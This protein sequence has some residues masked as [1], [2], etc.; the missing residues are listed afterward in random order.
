MK[1]CVG[2]MLALL[3]LPVYGHQYI[4]NPS[5][6]FNAIQAAIDDAHDGDVVVLAPGLYVSDG[7]QPLLIDSK[8]I[9]LR[10]QDANDAGVVA[11]TVLQCP[12]QDGNSVP[13]LV[14][15]GSPAL[16]TVL[17][18]I[19]VTGGLTQAAIR[20][21]N[22]YCAIRSCVIR[23]NQ[24]GGI[25]CEGSRIGL[26]QCQLLHNQAENGGGLYTE[27]ATV[28]LIDCL[29]QG[30]EAA[31]EGGAVY[32]DDSDLWGDRSQWIGNRA[33]AG[34]GLYTDY[35]T[36][37]DF[38]NCIFLANHASR[39]GG[40]I[41][42]RIEL[43]HLTGCILVGNTAGEEGG[44][45]LIESY[46]S[47][48]RRCLSLVNT[49]VA[50][51][52]DKHGVGRSVAGYTNYGSRGDRGEVSFALSCEY[53]VDVSNLNHSCLQLDPN[54]TLADVIDIN[55]TIWGDPLFV[56]TPD[57]GGD[58]WGDDPNTPDV[59]ESLNDDY[60]DLS[61]RWDS[62]CID[63]GYSSGWDYLGDWDVQG[64]PRV[65]GAAVDI[66]AIERPCATIH[67]TH[68][69]GGEVWAAGSVHQLTW[70]KL[71]TDAN[72]DILVNDDNDMSRQVIASD[73][74]NT[75]AYDWNIP[76][77]FNSHSVR[78]RVILS[79]PDPNQFVTDS[80][81]FAVVPDQN[82]VETVSPW[83]T[84]AGNAQ[85]TGQA[86]YAG[87]LAPIDTLDINLPG[88]LYT[89]VTLGYEDRLHVATEGGMLYTFNSSG[90]PLWSVDVNTPLLTA[91]TVGPDGS[92]YVG[93]QDGRL[94]AFAHEGILRL[95]DPNEDDDEGGRPGRRSVAQAIDGDDFAYEGVLRWTW[96]TEGFLYAS[97]TVS[98]T[99][100][101]YVSGQNG[102]LYA[103]SRNGSLLWSFKIPGL[104]SFTEALLAAP[105]LGLHGEVLMGSFYEPR[106]YALSP[107][108]GTVLWSCLCA[109]ANAPSHSD[110]GSIFASAVVGAGGI[111]YQGLIDDP[112]LYV[113][114]PNQGSVL[115]TVDLCHAIEV[116]TSEDFDWWGGS[117]DVEYSFGGEV[118]ED[119]VEPGDSIWTEPALGPDGTMYVSLDD[120]YLR[121]ISPEGVVQW[122]VQLGTGQGFSLAVDADGM[123]YAAGDDGVLYVVNGQGQVAAA[124]P[125]GSS[126]LYPVI[127]SEGVLILTDVAHGVRIYND[128]F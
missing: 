73:I 6:G 106:L 26:Y 98:D 124:L 1:L 91:P 58:G 81:A 70:R 52:Q 15:A 50:F 10:S 117:V 82:G 49:I 55:E 14:F 103:L 92:V 34:G 36:F 112:N 51:N 43:M 113:I 118:F 7:N 86:L 120:P 61:L 102:T 99:G 42:F 41:S 12:V 96:Q 18:G 62:P 33:Q 107:E 97:A 110:R 40:G 79:T 31:E 19:T 65:M 4:V 94:Y 24:A 83:S 89:S 16:P 85:H 121:A 75:G 68:P 22:A 28:R 72:V 80:D 109:D 66:G 44:S 39:R 27:D 53:L 25:W 84:L 126:L 32:S 60:G 57:N 8:A 54:E 93:G 21:S 87:P 30:N 114:D 100:T 5:G 90:Q 74:D 71:A 67:V 104:G 88:E 101:I 76:E 77:D 95:I 122:I 20:C 13:A 127:G 111:L 9:T 17:A 38:Y 116:T 115:W 105:T 123:I 46:A 119:G 128:L 125:I 63:R 78:I 29:F 64:S 69:Q 37:S 56:C 108:D 48:Y 47:C 59:D 45:I 35:S 11:A 3:T 2:L 23:E